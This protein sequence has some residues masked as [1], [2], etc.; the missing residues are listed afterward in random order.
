MDQNLAV[1]SRQQESERRK[2]ANSLWVTQPAFALQESARNRERERE[3]HGDP[4][5]WWNK[6]ALFNSV[7]L[8]IL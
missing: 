1:Q 5:L 8:Y 6:G 2:E 3:G 4:S 7:R